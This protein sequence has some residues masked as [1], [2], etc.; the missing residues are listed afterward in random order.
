MLGPLSSHTHSSVHCLLCSWWWPFWLE[1]D[2]ISKW[3]SFTFP[4]WL[5]ML[6]TFYKTVPAICTFSS[7]NYLLRS[8]AYFLIELFIFLIYSFLSSLYIL[9]PNPVSDVWLEKS[10][11]PFSMLPFHSIDRFLAVQIFKFHGSMCWLLALFPERPQS[12][13]E[14]HKPVS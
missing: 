5:V 9:D 12:N 11:L 7:E 13:W 10:F 8:M 6:D 4:W 2:G 1:S 14:Q 3:L